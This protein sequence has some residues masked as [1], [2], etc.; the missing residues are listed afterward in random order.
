MKITDFP[1]IKAPE[2]GRIKVFKPFETKIKSD[3]RNAVLYFSATNHF[4]SITTNED[5]NA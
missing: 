2:I 1:A 3:S 4:N 5:I